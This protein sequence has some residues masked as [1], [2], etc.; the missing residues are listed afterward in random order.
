MLEEILKEDNNSKKIEQ[1]F[2]ICVNIFYTNTSA[3]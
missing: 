1:N 2:K 3:E